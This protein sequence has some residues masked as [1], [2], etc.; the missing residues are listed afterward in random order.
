MKKVVFTILFF[1]VIIGHSQNPSSPHHLPDIVIWENDTLETQTSPLYQYKKLDIHKYLWE[2][3]I[4]P[5]YWGD[6]KLYQA[7]WKIKDDSLYLS[8]IYSK[9]YEEDNYK[10]D[11]DSLF[12]NYKNGLVTADW[13]TGNLF[14]PKGKYIRKSVSPGFRVFESEWKITVERGKIIG[15]IFKTN[16]YYESIYTQKNDSLKKFIIR[17]IDWVNIP[18][19]KGKE[20]I[21]IRFEIGNSKKNFK[22][23]VEA[24]NDSIKKEFKRVAELLPEFS[25]YYRHGEVINMRYTLLIT[26]SEEMRK[27]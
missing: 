10:A 18:I 3:G 25:Y 9:D 6:V 4:R 27:E 16:N 12:N 20:R 11:L 7:E 2:K 19:I 13:F 24:D 23:S 15:E 14:I 26:L 1:S 17:E 21:Q 8:N 22:I 5:K